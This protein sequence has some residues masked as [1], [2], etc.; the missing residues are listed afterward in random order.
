MATYCHSSENQLG[1]I[2]DCIQSLLSKNANE[3]VENVKSLRF[4]SRLFLVPR[5][6]QMWRPV[7]D[8]SRLDTFL[9]VEKLKMETPESI[10]TS[11]IP[12]EWVSLIDGCL[13]SHPHPPKLFWHR[14]QVFQFTSLPFGEA[15][16][17]QVFTMIV[18]EVKLMAFSRG[19]RLHQYLDDWLIGSQSQ[20]EAQVNTPAVVDLTQSLG[21]IINQEKSELKPTRVF[22]FVGYEYHLDSALVKPTQE[23]WL[24]LQDL[25]LRL[26]SKY[27]LTARCLMSLIG[28]LAS[29]E[30]MVPEGRLHMRPFQFH[31]KEHWRY[32]QSLDRSN[33]CTPRLVAK[34]HKCD[35]RRRSPSQRPQHLTFYRHLKFEPSLLSAF[36]KGWI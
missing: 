5:P 9:H 34:P 29:T 11:L 26:K 4:Y 3:R 12:G 17:P 32:P 36:Y 6:H 24:K 16:P 23:R 7:I 10:R 1:Q 31:L 27:V 21:W 33:F 14:S 20:E 25:I 8:S 28:L 30:K 19:L 18:K 22:L 35:D 2:S 13:P 15:T